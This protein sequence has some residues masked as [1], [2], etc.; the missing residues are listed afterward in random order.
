M[1][2]ASLRWVSVLVLAVACRAAGPAAPCASPVTAPVAPAAPVAAPVA[3]PSAPAPTPAPAP[4]PR[5]RVA[6]VTLVTPY[7]D[8]NA[9]HYAERMTRL[10]QSVTTQRGTLVPMSDPFPDCVVDIQPCAIAAGKR[11]GAEFV[12]YGILV[13]GTEAGST[14][15]SLESVEVSSAIV[16]TWED[17]PMDSDH[18]FELSARS[19]YAALVEA[20]PP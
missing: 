16:R 3:T 18:F 19:A 4:A 11:V 20:P 5:R 9:P 6:V 15:I 7:G 13:H 14:E 17:T 2:S 12:I 1:S 8:V 10:L